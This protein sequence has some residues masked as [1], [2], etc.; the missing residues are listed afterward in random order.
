[1]CIIISPPFVLSSIGKHTAQLMSP[2]PIKTCSDGAIRTSKRI[3]ASDEPLVVVVEEAAAA[4]M[5]MREIWDNNRSNPQQQQECKVPPCWE[6][7]LVGDF[8]G[9]PM[10]PP[11]IIVYST[12]PDQKP[13]TCCRPGAAAALKYMTVVE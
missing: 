13:E 11:P 12:P 7:D 5:M 1:V 8:E 10:G 4:V 6:V 3:Y 9:E 2:N